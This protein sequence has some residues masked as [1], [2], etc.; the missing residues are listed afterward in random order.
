MFCYHG[1][2]GRQLC[3]SCAMDW[4]GEVVEHEKQ[5][6]QHTFLSLVAF[7]V[8]CL[9]LTPCFGAH[10]AQSEP[11]RAIEFNK[12]VRP[13]LSDA[14][15]HCHGFDPGTRKANLRLDSFEGATAINKGRQALKPGDPA[16]SE[17]WRRIS[18]TNPQ[19]QMPP[20]TSGKKITPE[21][22]AALREWIQ[23]GGAY[24]KHWAFEPPKRPDPPTVKATGWP[25]NDLDRF[26]L[27]RLEAEKLQPSAPATR[28][29]LARR[30]TLDLTGL[31][32]TI[33]E[34]D[35]FLAD[36]DPEAYERLVDRLL[37][38]PRYGEHMARYWL[39]VARYGDTHGLHLDNERSM[40][41]YR[42]WVVEAFNQQPAVRPVHHRAAGGR[43]AAE[44]HA[45]AD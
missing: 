10:G 3:M 26:I 42:D 19:E 8:T 2:T 21:Q 24:Q 32:P 1:A 43:P 28:E 9:L 29:T 23:Q 20:P 38:S 14:C 4:S 41:P 12:Q 6:N 33:E 31:P 30:V 22:V 45:R 34:L 25:K 13:I 5:N 40:W 35:A 16:G 17:L 7:G 44:P 15:F 37:A 11:S 36:T 39:D 18:S 27:A